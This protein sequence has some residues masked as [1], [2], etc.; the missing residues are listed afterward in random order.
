MQGLWPETG[1]GST[2]WKKTSYCSGTY[3]PCSLH[4]WSP[5]DRLVEWL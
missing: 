2:V 5:F 1:N 4:C 3:A